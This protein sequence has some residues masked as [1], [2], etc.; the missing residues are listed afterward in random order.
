[1]R[2]LVT[3][4]R[5]LQGDSGAGRAGGGGAPGPLTSRKLQY[6]LLSKDLAHVRNVESGP[7]AS[8]GLTPGF[9][10]DVGDVKSGNRSPSVFQFSCLK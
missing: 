1:M 7:R 4:S 2:G 10:H 5:V 3:M 8:T 9:C 6:C